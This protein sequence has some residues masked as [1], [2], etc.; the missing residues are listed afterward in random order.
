MNAPS[1]APR[2]VHLRADDGTDLAGDEIAGAAPSLLFLHGLASTRIGDKSTSLLAFARTHR[3]G[4]LRLDMR[5]HG[6]STGKLQD[7]T[8]TGLVADARA[9]LDHLGRAW[10][11]GSSL[12]G[13]VGAWLA[14]TEPQRVEGLVL[15][16]PAFGFLRRMG[17]RPR[18][19][20]HIVIDSA[21]V[22]VE[23]HERVLEDARR[24]PEA[25]L[26]ARLSMPTLIVHG[27]C[28]DVVPAG[29][30]EQ[31]FAQIPHARKDLWL[32]PEGD[33]RLQAHVEAVWPRMQRLMHGA[34]V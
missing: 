5:G 32:V 24:W 18:H 6:E 15:L 2:R 4:L 12:G 11:V 26:G 17:A 27:A 1:E 21:F 34:S 10:I 33:H 25:E 3:L 14:A 16:A 7:M 23:V 9:A 29:D 28:D 20:N 19:G 13:L 31:L 8:L 22:R 30:S